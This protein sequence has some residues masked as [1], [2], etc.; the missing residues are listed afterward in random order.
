MRRH[1]ETA[2]LAL[3]LASPA[4][5]RSA[6][7]PPAGTPATRT[8]T[9]S[10]SAA[11]RAAADGPRAEAA[12]LHPEAEWRRTVPK[13]GPPKPP[14]L[15][16]FQTAKLRNGLTVIVP[17]ERSL[18]PLVG[19]E[20]VSKGG[21]S[22]DP[23]DKAGLASLTYAMLNEGAGKRDAIQFSDA[24]ADLGA[25]FGASADRDRASAV[26][27]GLQR[28]MDA[29]VGL[30]ADAVLRPRM[31]KKDFERRKE[32]MVAA[33]ERNRGSP[34]GL[35]FEALPAL[36]YGPSHPFGHPHTGTV[37]TVKN[38]TLAEVRATRARMLVPATSALVAAG[39]ITLD[40]AVKLAE[41]HFGK[42]NAKETPRVAIPSVEAKPRGEVLIVDKSPAPQTMIAIGRPIFGKGDPDE[43][44]MTVLNE[45]YGGAFTSRLNMNLRESK[46]YTYGASSQAVY[47]SSVGV[48]VAFSAVRQDVTAQGLQEFFNELEGLSKNPPTK[49]E[50]SLAKAGIIRALTGNFERT[51]ASAV[52]A[53]AI[54]VYDL[55]LDYYRKLG[56]KF[57]SVDVDA[58]HRTADKYMKP[59][60]MK[61]LLVGD[62]KQIMPAVELTKLGPV[63]VRE[64]P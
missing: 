39:D 41:K 36:I 38:L 45:I 37:E 7:P 32:Q 28:N 1:L 64:K 62:A 48:F 4:C 57:E 18:L 14:V 20:L 11:N 17:A 29:M 8:G 59:E 21:A 49:D 42:W 34:Q 63:V 30:L 44:P 61:V 6:A 60:L 58:V 52:A 31:E 22:T 56:D 53:T 35:A 2:L 27:G 24:V 13:G 26:I 40:Q 43:A 46:G 50:V 54:Y 25:Q 47:R 15:P 33:L 12:P 9:S 51:A 55:P 23:Q 16:A 19:F 3:L 5:R 10:A